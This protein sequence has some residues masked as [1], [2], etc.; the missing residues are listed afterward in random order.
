MGRSKWSKAMFIAIGP[1]AKQIIKQKI[2][3]SCEWSCKHS[4]HLCTLNTKTVND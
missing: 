4:A 3:G 2:R 1:N